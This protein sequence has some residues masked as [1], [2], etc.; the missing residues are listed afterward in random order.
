MSGWCNKTFKVNA[1]WLCIQYWSGAIAIGSSLAAGRW[2]MDI[3]WWAILI[4][5]GTFG[6][7]SCMIWGYKKDDSNHPSL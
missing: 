3:L 5:L 6:Y 1:K 4:M 7:V 2:G